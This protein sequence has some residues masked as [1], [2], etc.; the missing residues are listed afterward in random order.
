MTH[1]QHSKPFTYSL[2]CCSVSKCSTTVTTNSVTIY[3]F[4]GITQQ[5]VKAYIYLFCHSGMLLFLFTA[6]VSC[7]SHSWEIWDP[8]NILEQV[9]IRMLPYFRISWPFFRAHIACLNNKQCPHIST[10]SNLSCPRVWNM[11][12]KSLCRWSWILIQDKVKHSF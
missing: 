4:H 12:R 5:F 1:N 3:N 2:S 11:H 7:K 10:N 9:L 6:T 8:I